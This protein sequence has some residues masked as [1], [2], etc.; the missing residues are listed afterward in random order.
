MT[1][2]SSPLAPA[3]TT[4]PGINKMKSNSWEKFWKGNTAGSAG[5]FFTFPTIRL[6]GGYIVFAI[7]NKQVSSPSY[8]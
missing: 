4:K 7:T 3:T 1:Y 8:Q 2:V 6:E 5:A